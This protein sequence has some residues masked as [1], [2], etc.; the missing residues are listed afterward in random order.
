MER[1]PPTRTVGELGRGEWLFSTIVIPDDRPLEAPA[2][3]KFT[4]QPQPCWS[5]RELEEPLKTVEFPPQ[6]VTQWSFLK[7]PSLTESPR[8][9]FWLI[10]G[11]H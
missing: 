7:G 6:R 4:W 1:I 9:S 2:D 11:P 8:S 5:P 3:S 10:P